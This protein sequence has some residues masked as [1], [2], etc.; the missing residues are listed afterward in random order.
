MVPPRA[1]SIC[2]GIADAWL[3]LPPGKP[4]SGRYPLCIAVAN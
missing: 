3:G 1:P 2:R 4:G